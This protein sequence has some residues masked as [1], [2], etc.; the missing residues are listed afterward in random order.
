MDDATYRSPY[1]V[2]ETDKDLEQKGIRLSYGDFWFDVARAGGANSRFAKMLEKELQPY[3]RA[4]QTETMDPKVAN[5]ILCRC[6][7]ATV[8]TGWGSKKHGEG[9]M[10]ARDGSALDFSPANVAHVFVDLP[11]LFADVR[12]Q[13]SKVALFRNA[14]NEADA[15]N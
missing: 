1:D 4:I 7:A 8:V 2:F 12:E 3:R 10:I 5:E 15:G 14:V 13:A 6:F 9:R 11:D